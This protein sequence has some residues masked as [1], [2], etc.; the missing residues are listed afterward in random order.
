M[1]KP[2]FVSLLND[3]PGTITDDLPAKMLLGHA[4][5]LAELQTTTLKNLCHQ[6]HRASAYH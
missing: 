3:V 1:I 5:H 2:D 4:A 6:I